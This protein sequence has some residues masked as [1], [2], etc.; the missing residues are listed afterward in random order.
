MRRRFPRAMTAIAIA[1]LAL[2]LS[3]NN[4]TGVG[5]LALEFSPAALALA[6]VRDTTVEVRNTGSA[7]LGPIELAEGQVTN[8]AGNAVT[9]FALAIT[10]RV[11][12]TLNPGDVQSVALSLTVPDNTPNGSYAFAVEAQ[13][14]GTEISTSVDVNFTVV[15]PL[16]INVTTVTFTTA[17]PVPTRQGDVVHLA[18]EARDAAG[19][20]VDGISIDYA[21]SPASQGLISRDGDFVG[22]DPGPALIIEDLTSP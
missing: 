18:A 11:I 10:P 20:L 7:P 8:S 22:Y 15:D 17:A 21:V 19:A 13:V 1:A 5:N 3:C 6:A 12:A 14:L 4:S 9:G 16:V 2:V